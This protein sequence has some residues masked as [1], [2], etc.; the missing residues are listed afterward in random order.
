MGG[1]FLSARNGQVAPNCFANIALPGREHLGQ[2]MYRLTSPNLIVHHRHASRPRTCDSLKTYLYS[3]IMKYPLIPSNSA[4]GRCCPHPAIPETSHGVKCSVDHPPL[5]TCP[6]LATCLG[7]KRCAV[8]FSWELAPF[9]DRLSRF[10][11]IPGRNL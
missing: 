1:P 11:L 8:A 9:G 3:K 7:P 6:I 4:D 5:I 10:S 2:F